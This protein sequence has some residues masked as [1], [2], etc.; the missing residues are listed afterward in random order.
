MPVQSHH[1][2]IQQHGMV[3]Y[4]LQPYIILDLLA[5]RLSCALALPAPPACCHST[6][7]WKEPQDIGGDVDSG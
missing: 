6:S 7:M 2:C 3:L 5:A 1:Y 4:A